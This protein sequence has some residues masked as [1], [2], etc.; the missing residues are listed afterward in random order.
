[1]QLQNAIDIVQ[2]KF[3]AEAQGTN[4]E[5]INK[6]YFDAFDNCPAMMETATQIW[7]AQLIA[8]NIQQQEMAAE[9]AQQQEAGEA[10]PQA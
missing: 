9:A 6:R 2:E 4:D 10:A 7:A 8:Q 3:M 5:S 1:M